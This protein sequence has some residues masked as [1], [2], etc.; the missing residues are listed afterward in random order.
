[1]EEQ[2]LGTA[3]FPVRIFPINVLIKQ[4]GLKQLAQLER[5][6]EGVEDDKLEDLQKQKWVWA[7]SKGYP[8]TLAWFALKQ[9]YRVRNLSFA[10]VRSHFLLL[11]SVVLVVGYPLQSLVILNQFAGMVQSWTFCSGFLQQSGCG[12]LPSYKW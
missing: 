2:C 11:I 8:A 4:E 12:D 6:E 9:P 5:Q 7:A 3:S 10:L 1:M